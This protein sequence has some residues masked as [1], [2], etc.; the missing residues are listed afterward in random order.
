RSAL[1][2]FSQAVQSLMGDADLEIRGPRSGFGEI[3]YSRIVQLTEV[4][5]ASPIVEVDAKIPGQKDTLRIVG[6]DVF[7]AGS[8]HP[9]L[10]GRT[11]SSIK[12][13]REAPPALLDPD[14]IFLSPAALQ[15]LGVEAGRSLEAQVGLETVRLRIAG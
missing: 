2:E 7:R 4:A 11:K 8:V 1:N 13:D 14:A 15:W 3:L 9:D 10:V 12:E 5:D 6:I